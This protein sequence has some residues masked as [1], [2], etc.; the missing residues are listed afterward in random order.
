MFIIPTVNDWHLLTLRYPKYKVVSNSLLKDYGVMAC[1]EFIENLSAR[2]PSKKL[3]ILELGH[4]FNPDVLA[5]FQDKH[6][7]WGADRDQQLSYFKGIGDWEEKFAAEVSTRCPN[8]KFIRELL[9][10]SPSAIPDG[11]FDVILSISVLEEVPLNILREIVTAAYSKLKPGGLLIGTHDHCLKR[12]ER[13][14]DYVKIQR[15]AG[16]KLDFSPRQLEI[17]WS[18]VLLEN[19]SVVMRWYQ[20]DSPDDASR[21]YWGHF[22]TIFTVARKPLR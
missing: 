10:E 18:I 16:F 21:K 3:R 9:G 8:V 14:I 7:C 19:P 5:Y 22:G 13:A 15:N 6:E 20:M 12:K 4:G 17:D 1:M 11:Y 2:E